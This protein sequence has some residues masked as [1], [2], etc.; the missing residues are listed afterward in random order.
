M[1]D[2]IEDAPIYD[3]DERLALWYFNLRQTFVGHP[4]AR[5]SVGRKLTQIIVNDEV[6]IVRR[7]G[8]DIDQNNW[9]GRM[10][11]NTLLRDYEA[12]IGG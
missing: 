10:Q 3:E 8:S 6:V 11:A 12:L 9:I 1:D 7:F 4:E 5:I 2:W